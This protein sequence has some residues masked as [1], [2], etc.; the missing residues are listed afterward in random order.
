MI[1]QAISESKKKMKNFQKFFGFYGPP[2]ILSGLRRP[3]S[4]ADPPKPP[5]SGTS[6]PARG[7]IIG[8]ILFFQQGFHYK[9]TRLW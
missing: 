9:M 6:S 4:P 1:Q 2:R 5:F 8:K 3:Q 7:I